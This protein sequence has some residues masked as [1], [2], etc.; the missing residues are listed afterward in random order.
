MRLLSLRLP[1]AGVNKARRDSRLW[2]TNAE[3]RCFGVE[4]RNRLVATLQTVETVGNG[5]G[6]ARHGR[7]QRASMIDVA[8][9]RYGGAPATPA[10]IICSISC[11]E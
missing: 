5:P 3:D 7:F 9:L 2:N 1:C 10:S 8:I 6:R 11:P 4:P